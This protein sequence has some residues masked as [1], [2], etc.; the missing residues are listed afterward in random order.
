MKP[1]ARKKL[2]DYMWFGLF[3][4]CV[5]IARF[6]VST[7]KG[8]QMENPNRLAFTLH[9]VWVSQR[10]SLQ[11]GQSD[12]LQPE[13]FV[14][15]QEPPGFNVPPKESGSVKDKHHLLYVYTVTL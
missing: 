10:V 5:Y 9:N 4:L 2:I 8:G 12:S 6:V 13:T 11:E 15:T 1:N 14:Q 7:K 3:I